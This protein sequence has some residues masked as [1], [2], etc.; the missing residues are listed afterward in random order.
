MFSL[1]RNG[2][3]LFWPMEVSR[4]LTPSSA[5]VPQPKRH[6]IPLCPVLRRH[7]QALSGSGRGPCSNSCSWQRGSAFQGSHHSG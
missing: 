4:G 7:L 1:L 2:G 3:L 5:M 6:L